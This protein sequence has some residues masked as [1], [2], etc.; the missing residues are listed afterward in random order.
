MKAAI[1]KSGASRRPTIP[2]KVDMTGHELAARMTSARKVYTLP[3]EKLRPSIRIAHRLTGDLKIPKRIILDHELV[4][5]LSGKGTLEIKSE[6][7][8]F[9]AGDLLFIPPFTPHSFSPSGG[10]IEHLAVHFDFAAQFPPFAANLARRPAY[11]VRLAQGL[12][13][14]QLYKTQPS[15]SIRSW[16][17]SLVPLFTLGDPLSRLRAE[18][19]LLI[20]LTTLLQ[21]AGAKRSKPKGDESINHTLYARIE[22]AVDYIEHHFAESITP[23]DLAHAAGMSVSHF[24]RLFHR[25]AAQSP[26]QFVLNRRVQEAR[27]LL[28]DVNL[29]V[30]EVAVRCGFEDPYYFSKVFRR[31]DGLPP[32]HFREAQLAGRNRA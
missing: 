28:G 22:R 25:W 32:S 23:T 4:L 14:P 21:S 19:L 20:V 9:S 8:S 11:K 29:S 12:A 7:I 13:L 18:A 15:D 10:K 27:K 16:L 31:I 17:L 1:K 3:L 26:G 30:K 5:I 6:A 2:M 24:N